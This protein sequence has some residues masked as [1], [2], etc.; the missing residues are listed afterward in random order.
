MKVSGRAM[1]EN[2][3]LAPDWKVM[4][5]ETEEA[6]GP[7]AQKGFPLGTP[8]D[9]QGDLQEAEILNYIEGRKDQR[10]L[11]LPLL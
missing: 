6:I 3:I 2:C 10:N 9:T 11:G 8:R 5:S 4:L 1:G 7:R